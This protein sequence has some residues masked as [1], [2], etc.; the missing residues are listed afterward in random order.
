MHVMQ[1][2][3]DNSQASLARVHFKPHN[4]PSIVTA[5]SHSDLCK[6]NEITVDR[7]A[8]TKSHTI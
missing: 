1:L 6:V 7:L 4:Q 5:S 8:S 2:N 3:N